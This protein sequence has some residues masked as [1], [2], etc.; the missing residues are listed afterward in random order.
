M[1]PESPART[2][3]LPRPLKVRRAEAQYKV[4]G[5]FLDLMRIS[6]RVGGDGDG[7]KLNKHSIIW[8]VGAEA[9]L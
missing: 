9:R 4:W 5:P 8:A 1:T 2:K 6:G 3:A 7:G